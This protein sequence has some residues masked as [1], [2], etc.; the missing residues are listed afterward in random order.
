MP[1]RLASVALLLPVSS[2]LL[3]SP[4][5][6]PRAVVAMKEGGSR[7]SRRMFL[8]G[9]AAAVP[10]V[11]GAAVAHAEV[12]V[13]AP[14]EAL[15]AATKVTRAEDE[16]SRLAQVAAGEKA[17]LKALAENA[18]EAARTAQE[19]VDN[20]SEAAARSMADERAAS[21][22]TRLAN[23]AE[24]ATDEAM[25]LADE[26]NAARLD[27]ERQLADAQAELVKRKEDFTS[28]Y[29]MRNVRDVPAAESGGQ[30][31]ESRGELQQN[32]PAEARLFAKYFALVDKYF[33][34]DRTQ[35]TVIPS[36]LAVLTFA[37]AAL[38]PPS[39][40]AT[41][42]PAYPNP[43]P[44]ATPDDAAMDEAQV[45]FRAQ[46]SPPAAAAA[47]AYKS[48]PVADPPAGPEYFVCT[49]LERLLLAPPPGSPL[50]P[51]SAGHP[52][53][54]ARAKLA[55]SVRPSWNC[56]S[57]A[58]R[59][60]REAGVPPREVAEALRAAKARVPSHTQRGPAHVFFSVA[61]A[62]GGRA[63]P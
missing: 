1:W 60:A 6:V 25:R 4:A 52:A 54:A 9:A 5:K 41:P 62:A 37:S 17:R 44:P 45:V 24:R 53:A 33:G 50:R 57:S 21:E 59:A 2:A 15:A 35:A 14:P 10:L 48:P 19:A 46:T 23:A 18:W 40:P 29:S 26:A 20:A 32:Q 30:A 39:A 42:A 43:Y 12:A 63:F 7:S 55:A 11:S 31:Q 28:I 38:P 13:E 51:A 47:P 8:A 27:R 58:A 34:L 16:V 36:L 49:A 61:V 22:A 56:V 3:V